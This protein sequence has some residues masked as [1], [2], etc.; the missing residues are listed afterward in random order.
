[1][2]KLPKFLISSLIAGVLLSA[3]GTNMDPNVTEDIDEVDENDE[4]KTLESSE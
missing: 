4:M 1:M 3:C 2:K